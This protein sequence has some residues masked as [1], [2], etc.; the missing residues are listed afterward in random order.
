MTR[1]VC[2]RLFAGT[3]LRQVIP[4]S[5]NT[6]VTKKARA[7]RQTGAGTP[8]RGPLFGCLMKTWRARLQRL[9]KPVS[10]R[11]PTI[12]RFLAGGHRTLRSRSPASDARKVDAGFSLSRVAKKN[13]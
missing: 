1:T 11:A 13:T 8:A 6:F 3:F 5:P 2:C 4:T 7:H 9:G 12:A 10:R